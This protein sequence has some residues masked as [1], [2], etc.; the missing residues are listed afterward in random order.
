MSQNIFMLF[1]LIVLTKLL[2]VIYHF[3]GKIWPFPGLAVLNV[4]YTRY[5]HVPYLSFLVQKE[6]LYLYVMI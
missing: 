3:F 1:L 2:Q 6:L 4:P 5:Q